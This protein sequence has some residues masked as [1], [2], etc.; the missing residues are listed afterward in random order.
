[1]QI[2]VPGYLFQFAKPTQNWFAQ[3]AELHLW[4]IQIMPICYNWKL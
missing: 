1:M 2:L 3:E 4:L